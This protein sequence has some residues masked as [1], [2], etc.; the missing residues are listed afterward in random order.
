MVT[1][2]E[3]ARDGRSGFTLIEILVVV[4]IVGILDDKIVEGIVGTLAAEVDNWI[5]V[6]AASPA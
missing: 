1:S 4:A 6:T 5:A 2:A 3:P